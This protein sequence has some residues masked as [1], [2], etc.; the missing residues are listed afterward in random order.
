MRSAP[1]CALLLVSL[2]GCSVASPPVRLLTESPPRAAGEAAL[3]VV[4]LSDLRPAEQRTGKKPSLVPLLLWNQR[5]GHWVTGDASF[6]DAPQAAV[7]SGVAAAL[8]GGV[9]GGARLLPE[10]T[11][12]GEDVAALCRAEGLRYVAKGSIQ[13]LFAY[14]Y[15]RSYLVLIPTPW[16]GAIGWQ[17]TRSDPV[18][19]ARVHVRVVDCVSSRA[20]LELELASEDRYPTATLSQAAARALGEILEELRLRVHPLFRPPPPAP[21]PAPGPEDALEPL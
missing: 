19:V 3:G 15:Q 9:F 4:P 12:P 5:I 1:V 7:S 16:V 21:P 18:G 17:N 11:A 8:D 20:V 6:L 13:A 10:A 14:L 2:A